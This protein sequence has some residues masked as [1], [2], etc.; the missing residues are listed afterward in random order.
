MIFFARQKWDGQ[1]WAW[2]HDPLDF[3][4]LPDSTDNAHFKILQSLYEE[5][6]LHSVFIAESL[7][8]GMDIIV[9]WR[10]KLIRISVVLF[11]VG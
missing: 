5:K 1:W 2:T 9:V 3:K 4:R 6:Y 8:D 10:L 7:A 11:F